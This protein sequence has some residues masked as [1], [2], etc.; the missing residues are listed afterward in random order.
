MYIQMIQ[1]VMGGSNDDIIEENAKNIKKQ[2][3]NTFDIKDI[4][5]I[6]I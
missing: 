4:K 5:N 1:H 3:G 6:N 2:L